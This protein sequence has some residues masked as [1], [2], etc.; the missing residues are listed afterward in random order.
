[1]CSLVR[2]RDNLFCKS[3][4]ITGIQTNQLSMDKIK[5]HPFFFSFFFHFI[6]ED[7]VQYTNAQK[8]IHLSTNV[9]TNSHCSLVHSCINQF[10]P[11][12]VLQVGY[13]C[14]GPD[15]VFSSVLRCPH[16]QCC[17]VEGYLGTIGSL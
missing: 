17:T 11:S 16:I 2:G 1:M 3:H 14:F 4:D 5:S 12:I 6:V 15:A 7:S 8:Y 13:T 10:F 9:Y